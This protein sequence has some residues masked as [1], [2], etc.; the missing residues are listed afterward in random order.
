MPLALRFAFLSPSENSTL[1]GDIGRTATGAHRREGREEEPRDGEQWE[2]EDGEGVGEGEEGR[3][4]LRSEDDEAKELCGDE[5]VEKLCGEGESRKDVL[6]GKNVRGAAPPIVGAPLCSDGSGGGEGDRLP[7]IKKR[8]GL[9]QSDM[10]PDEGMRAAQA[11]AK[12]SV[13]VSTHR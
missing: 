10:M 2:G 8:A 7:L 11:D 9:P 3:I 6:D 12:E 1:E 13:T 5:K 4:A